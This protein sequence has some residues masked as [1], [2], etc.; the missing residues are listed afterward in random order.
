[1]APFDLLGRFKVIAKKR[2]R[3]RTTRFTQVLP[4]EKLLLYEL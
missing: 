3:F 2:D 1:M 4:E